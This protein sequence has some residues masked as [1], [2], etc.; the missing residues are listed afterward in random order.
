[1]LPLTLLLAAMTAG[2]S[3]RFTVHTT[4]PKPVVGQLQKLDADGT[5]TLNDPATI[6][7]PGGLVSLR[8]VD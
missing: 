4:E 3:P 5:L 6:V 7:P 8:R 1:M 2:Q